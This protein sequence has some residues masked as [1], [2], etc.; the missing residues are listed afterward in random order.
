MLVRLRQS[1]GQFDCFHFL[2]CRA[3]YCPSSKGGALPPDGVRRCTAAI[4]AFFGG[5][6]LHLCNTAANT[7]HNFVAARDNDDGAARDHGAN[8]DSETTHC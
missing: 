7:N 5:S 8:L 3:V 4:S 6:G 1:P 2:L